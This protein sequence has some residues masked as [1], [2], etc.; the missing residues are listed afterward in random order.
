MHVN[1]FQLFGRKE[2]PQ[3]VGFDPPSVPVGFVVGILVTGLVFVRALQ[4]SRI[5]IISLMLPIHITFI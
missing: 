2:T 4:I 1:A 5:F 3:K